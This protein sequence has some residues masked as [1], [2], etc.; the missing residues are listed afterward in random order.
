MGGSD[1]AFVEQVKGY[2][3]NHYRIVSPAN[4]CIKQTNPVRGGFQ[5]YKH[6]SINLAFVRQDGL[7]LRPS[8][9]DR[10]CT[11]RNGRPGRLT[12]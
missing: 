10:A 11:V 9:H 4:L 6:Q 3:R 2:E 12:S 8:R 7:V 5:E 1:P